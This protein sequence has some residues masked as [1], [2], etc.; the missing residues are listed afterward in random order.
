[1]EPGR[2]EAEEEKAFAM[3]QANDHKEK[4]EIADACV[5]LG[6][7][8]LRLRPFIEKCELFCERAL[9]M[10]P[11][12]DT[13]LMQQVAA[14]QNGSRPGVGSGSGY[15]QSVRGNPK[16]A[17]WKTCEALTIA[18][19]RLPCLERTFSTAWPHA[20]RYILP[21]EEPGA[22][23]EHTWPPVLAW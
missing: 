1:G 7:I 10:L 3:A 5:P 21:S 17:Y 15:A 20:V 4:S 11:D 22:R 12:E 23:L 16:A 13:E 6:T 2:R 19:L 8:D 14:T 18:A 9:E